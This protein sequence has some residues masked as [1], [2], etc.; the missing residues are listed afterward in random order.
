[1]RPVPQKYILEKVPETWERRIG[2]KAR[3]RVVFA[4]KLGNVP[5]S[6]FHNFLR[7]F[8]HV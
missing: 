4:D 7:L 1:V 3:A 6:G 2:A 8:T 5:D